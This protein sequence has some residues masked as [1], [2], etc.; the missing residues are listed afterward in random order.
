M[1]LPSAGDDNVWRWHPV[2]AGAARR[3]DLGWTAGTAEISPRAGGDTYYGK[4]LMLWRNG[5]GGPRFVA[6]IGNGRPAASTP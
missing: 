4:Y 3:G 6:D 5:N 1:G 2:A